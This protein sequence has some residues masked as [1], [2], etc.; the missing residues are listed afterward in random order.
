[1]KACSSRHSWPR[2]APQL[3]KSKVAVDG[4]Q[5]ASVLCWNMMG[6]A[7]CR[8]QDRKGGSEVPGD[9]RTNNGFALDEDGGL[10][11]RECPGF[12]S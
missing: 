4:D 9:M 1:M 7:L 10:G 8:P 11:P 3:P 2:F 6:R 5:L 12:V